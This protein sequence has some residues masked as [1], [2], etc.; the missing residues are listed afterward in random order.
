MIRTKISTFHLKFLV[1]FH[2]FF[3]IFITCLAQEHDG[4][5]LTF[6]AKDSFEELTKAYETSENNAMAFSFAKAFLLK[7][8]REN[9]IEKKTE[10]YYM[11]ASNLTKALAYNKALPYLDSAIAISKDNYTRIFPARAHILK[12]N[13]KGAQTHFTEA[14][15]E[16]AIASDYAKKTDN[17]DQQYDIKFFIALLKNNVGELE[18]GLS[19]LKES[20]AYRKEQFGKDSIYSHW[21]LHAQFAVASQF[22]DLK[23][24]DSALVYLKKPMAL[25]LKLKDS[26]V[27][28][29]MLLCT[30]NSLNLKSEYQS[31]LDSLKKY[32]AFIRDVEVRTGTEFRIAYWFGNIYSKQGKKETALPYLKRMDSLAFADSFFVEA[33][34]ENYGHLI[35]YYKEKK[36]TKQQLF[37]INRL[38]K[39]DSILDSDFAYLSKE[40]NASYDTPNLLQEKEKLIEELKKKKG[41]T[42]Y[43]LISLAVLV[44]V[45]ILLLIRYYGKQ[46]TYKKRFQELL[47]KTANA[48]HKQFN[49]EHKSLGNLDIPKEV[50]TAVLKKLEAFEQ[51]HGYL[52]LNLT[53]GGLAKECSTNSKY[54]SKIINEYKHKSFTNYINDLRIDYAVTTLQSNLKLRKYSIK[55]VAKEVGFNT[56]EAFSKS[57]YKSTGIYPSFYIKQ[58]EKQ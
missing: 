15:D 37:Y 34:K 47:E 12:A 57:F 21:Y 26:V 42:D 22:N 51:E 41:Q 13:I 30:V 43:I 2:L 25:A 38:L 7:A 36:D 52:K 29:R 8:K 48:N 1:V 27:Y 5:N 58:L 6:L 39:V 44:L 40:I 28:S 46:R 55:A 11:L 16:L 4:D 20:V 3:F 53:L 14:M 19:L 54:F 33:I 18:E 9:D 56:T 50:V 10:G 17:V 32:N 45:L 49:V 35:A 23:Q 24:P 31:S